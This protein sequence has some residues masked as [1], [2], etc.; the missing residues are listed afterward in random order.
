MATVAELEESIL[1]LPKEDF[2]QLHDWMNGRV[3][4][5]QDDEFESPELEAEILKGLDG[6]RIPVDEAFFASL[7]Q[8]IREAL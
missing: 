2:L 7:R 8:S 4:A 5:L 3:E 1:T 6:P